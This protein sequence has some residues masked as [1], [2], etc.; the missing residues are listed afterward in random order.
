MGGHRLCCVTNC[1]TKQHRLGTLS[2]WAWVGL[3]M[4]T[5]FNSWITQIQFHVKFYVQLK[6]TTNRGLH[7]G[8]VPDVLV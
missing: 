5:L 7:K 2:Y 1:R 3:D 8:R 4:G 6:W